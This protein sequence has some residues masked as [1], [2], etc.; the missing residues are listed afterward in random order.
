MY[1]SFIKWYDYKSLE[2]KKKFCRFKCAT[3]KQDG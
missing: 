3:S 2:L 1:D